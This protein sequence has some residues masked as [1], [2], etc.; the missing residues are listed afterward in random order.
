MRGR[1]A[2]SIA[3]ALAA[4]AVIAAC[5]GH[6]RRGPRARPLPASVCGPVTYD[7]EGAP[8]LLVA[9]SQSLQ[10]PFSDHGLQN[11]QAAKLVLAERGWRAGRFHVGLQVCD[12][13]DAATPLPSARKCAANAR[14]FAAERSVVAV[15]GPI[16]STCTA[17]MI[18]VLN[19]ASGGPVGLVGMS[20]TYLGLTRTGPGVERGDPDRLYP[21]GRRNFVR[22]VAAD[23]AQAAAGASYARGLGVRR[24]YVLHHD[25]TWGIGI[26]TAFRNAARKLGMTIA[27]NEGWDPRARSY[28]SLAER[29][30]RSGADA[31]YLAG[32]AIEN[33]PRLL[34]DL[35]AGL[36]R[37]VLVMGPDGFNMP[38]PLVEK[39]GAAADGLVLTLASL[40]VAPLPPAGRRFAR[41][42]EQRFGVLPCCYAVNAGQVMAVVL[43]AIAKSDGTRASVL[44]HLFRT[45]IRHGLL[46]DVAVDRYG[47]SS[48]RSIAVYR[49]R[50]ARARFVTA[51]TPSG[52]LLART[53]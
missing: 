34:R 8:E 7:G 43:D 27:G 24:P 2:S 44:R 1:A 50:A 41:D 17:A 11:A 19:R 26:A 37:R 32:Y 39:A 23:D 6:D 21:T 47:D 4:V 16:T 14:Q 49:I 38:A 15:T 22:I 13:A 40:P 3:T 48:V 33:G 18:P 5:G 45:H 29:I 20:A 52:E 9:A 46:G 30:R 53:P 10:P 12:E 31:V 51:I 35:R 36:G 42:F 25:Q 28:G